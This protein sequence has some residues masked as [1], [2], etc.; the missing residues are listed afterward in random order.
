MLVT[1]QYRSGL[2]YALNVGI[3]ITTIVS[4]N[5][6]CVLSTLVVF[7]IQL[8][9]DAYVYQGDSTSTKRTETEKSMWTVMAFLVWNVIKA[10]DVLVTLATLCVVKMNI[11]VEKVFCCPKSRWCI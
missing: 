6:W 9:V 4:C 11:E 1:K 3:I 8:N 5:N 2:L 7:L 10:Q